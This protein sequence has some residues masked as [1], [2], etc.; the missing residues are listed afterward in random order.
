M[1][2]TLKNVFLWLSLLAGSYAASAQTSL[3]SDG[4]YFL[5]KNYTTQNG[6]LQNSIYSIAQDRDGYI[7]IGS[8]VGLTRFDGKTFFHKAIPAIFNNLAT[9]HYIETA[10][11]G[12]IICT[13]IMQG[14]FVQQDNGQFK[15][16]L[17]RG[18]VEL[19][20]NVFWSVKYCPDGRILAHES[21]CIYLLTTDTLQQFYDLGRDGALFHSIEMDKENRIWFGG[22][23][24]LGVMQLSDSVYE[25][26]F[27]PEFKDKLIVKILFDDE[28]TLHV[29]TSQGYYRIKWRQP[30]QMGQ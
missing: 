4:K 9:V 19:G 23:M 26:V 1:K 29:G 6:L 12:N 18:Y 14:V 21:R 15:Q 30:Y 20:K 3:T 2:A 25:P 5:F 16:Y 24:G 27:L 7:W 28:G 17:K 22:R 10:P 13:S 8:N 11:D